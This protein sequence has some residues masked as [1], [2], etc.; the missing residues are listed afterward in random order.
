M[1]SIEVIAVPIDVVIQVSGPYD[2]R[3]FRVISADL[4]TCAASGKTAQEARENFSAKAAEY[5]G[6]LIE[7]DGTAESPL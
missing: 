6:G 4:L 1:G 2:D 5:I 7:A 3:M